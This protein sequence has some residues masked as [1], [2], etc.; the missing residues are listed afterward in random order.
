MLGISKQNIQRELYEKQDF[1]K[2]RR[3]LED[4]LRTPGLTPKE[5]TWARQKLALATYKDNELQSETALENALTI[6]R[7]EGLDSTRNP[8]TLSLAGAIHKR[9]WQVDGDVRAL[10]RSLRYY[11]SACSCAKSAC[12]GAKVAGDAARSE[13]Q[14]EKWTYAGINAAFVLDL[15]AREE[16]NDDDH[17]N[18]P[19]P[20]QLRRA[21][22]DR[23]RQ[24]ICAEHDQIVRVTHPENGWWLRAS[25]V[26]AYFGLREYDKA[27]KLLEDGIRSFTPDNWKKESMARQLAALARLHS[28]SPAD[29]APFQTLLPLISAKAA[30]ALLIGKVGLALSGGGFRAALFHAGVLAH[31]A[32]LDLL[33]HVEVL[34]CVSG[35]SILGA[36]YYL[37]LRHRLQTTADQ[38]M[39]RNVYVEIV[40]T[41]QDK[42]IAALRRD[43]RTRAML[44]SL[45]S[46]TSR[47][48]A[49]TG[50]MIDVALYSSEHTPSRRLR[51]LIVI[52][53]GETEKFHPKHHN[54]RREAKVP[55]L[56]LNAT[57]LNT[58]HNWQF[59]QTYMGEAPT[60]LEPAVDAVERLR[61]VYYSDAPSPHGDIE[62]HTAVAA[63]AAVP[64]VFRPIC[65]KR[66]YEGNRVVRLSDGGVH[67]N[68]GI[69][70]LLEQDCNIIIVSDGCG[71]L[72]GE[73]KPAWLFT[74]VLG[75]SNNILMD[76]VRRNCYRILAM[77]SRSRR[78]RELH[79]MHLKRGLP[80]EDV[81]W[82]DGPS[83]PKAVPTDL[84]RSGLNERRQR[85]LA[86]IR[87]DLDCF[88]ENECHAL[89]FAGYRIAERDF[90]ESPAFARQ[91]GAVPTIQWPFLRVAALMDEGTVSSAPGTNAFLEELECGRHLFFRPLRSSRIGRA[92]QRLRGR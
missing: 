50:E 26:E 4:Y 88:S 79:F 3:L 42:L 25:L 51:D 28:K 69:F 48:T 67:D 58:G 75:R 77:R 73:I 71:Q 46:L 40:R 35:G 59:T 6:L 23:H 5:F 11:E 13:E 85:A 24:E 62:L 60:S 1:S 80:T 49:L 29:E 12:E 18:A 47:R 34:S 53:Y 27:A 22:A 91:P 45:P 92:W 84:E 55:M 32:E 64:G 37:E 78:I 54:W 72:T 87:T 90:A 74:R 36:L 44:Q 89:M 31:L 52:P 63:S 14:L 20:A 33:R 83:E 86:A 43:I 17:S 70:G 19:D 30:C 81:T 82:R 8:E 76:T 2:A 9:L 39:D 41:V 21:E 16:E 15:L 66:L 68:Q 38:R 61:R 10:T 7:S 57:S 56:I 65:F